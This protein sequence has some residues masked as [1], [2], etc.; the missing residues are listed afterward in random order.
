M[1]SIRKWVQRFTED[2][3]IYEQGK[4]RK[5]I[6]R[7]GPADIVQ[8]RL[9]GRCKS[10]FTD[11]IAIKE[12]FWVALKRTVERQWKAKNKEREAHGK[13]PLKRPTILRS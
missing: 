8:F 2:D 7:L 10:S 4:N 13:R 5:I 6:V 12:L 3:T 11:G 1:T 9:A